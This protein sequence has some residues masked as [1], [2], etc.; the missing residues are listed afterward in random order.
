MP[1]K[2]LAAV[3]IA[4]LVALGTLAGCTPDPAPTASPT[5]P[6]STTPTSSPTPTSTASAPPSPTAT[7]DPAPSPDPQPTTPSAG[8]ATPFITVASLDPDGAH[9]SAS[10][11]IVDVIESG[12]ICTFTFTLGDTTLLASSTGVADRTSTSCPLVQLPAS[13]FP[14]GTW[15]VGLNYSSASVSLGDAQPVQ[16]VIS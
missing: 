16:M 4:A 1:K 6:A 10:G 12:G 14:P 3:S 2:R 11:Y 9:V 13:Q 7:T 5:L 8:S 15:Q